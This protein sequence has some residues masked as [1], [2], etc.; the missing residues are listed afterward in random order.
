MVVKLGVILLCFDIY[1]SWYRAIISAPSSPPHA[2]GI[3]NDNDGG[4]GTTLLAQY[5]HHAILCIVQTLATHL[6][7]RL[8]ASA[9]LGWR[10]GGNILSTALLISSG[11]RFLPVL[12]V[13]FDYGGK[14]AL[15]GVDLVVALFYNVEA[16]RILL[17]CRYWQSLTLAIAG[18]TARY[19]AAMLAT[20]LLGTGM[21]TSAW[22]DVGWSVHRS[23]GV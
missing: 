2:L 3:D 23:A 15:D 10:G 14:Q 6:V 12:M 18:L 1:L 7:Q 20:R 8:L 5:V 19:V 11:A 9:W 21:V 17:D 13:V 4:G 16:V 22:S